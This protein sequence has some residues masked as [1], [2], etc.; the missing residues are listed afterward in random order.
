MGKKEGL[1][2]VKKLHGTLI[3]LMTL[4][5]EANAKQNGRKLKW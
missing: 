1:K 5:M 4:M 3:A 2:N